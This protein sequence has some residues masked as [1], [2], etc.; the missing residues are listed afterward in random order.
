M[1]P[2]LRSKMGELEMKMKKHMM[3]QRCGNEM[4]FMN[5]LFRRPSPLQL[6]QSHPGVYDSLSEEAKKSILEKEGT[7][8]VK[9]YVSF[10]E[11]TLE[12]MLVNGKISTEQYNRLFNAVNEEG[13]EVRK[14]LLEAVGF[15][16]ITYDV[17][18]VVE[19]MQHDV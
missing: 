9:V 18:N 14:Q 7:A 3:E 1:T 8:M 17:E 16:I 4:R 15:Y 13:S 19:Y 6:R 5:S 11:S 10:M 12:Q 2:L